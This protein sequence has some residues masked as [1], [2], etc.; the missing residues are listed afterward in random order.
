MYK[1]I[2]CQADADLLQFDLTKV[3]EWAK[4]WLLRLNPD[5]CE[6][7]VLSNKRAPPMPLYYLDNKLISCKPV[8]RYLGVLVDHHLNWN[9]HCKYVAAKATRSLNFL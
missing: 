5:K 6:S 9:D 1:E 4:L 2:V 7:I 8:V 3:V